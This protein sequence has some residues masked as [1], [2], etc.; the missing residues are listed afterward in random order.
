MRFFIHSFVVTHS[1]PQPTCRASQVPVN[2]LNTG[3][4]DE[5]GRQDPLTRGAVALG[6]Q[7]QGHGEERKQ[8]EANIHILWKNLNKLLGTLAV[9]TANKDPGSYDNGFLYCRLMHMDVTGI[10]IYVHGGLILHT[11][12]KEI[13]QE[14]ASQR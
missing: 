13:G 5:Q 14:K 1:F 9:K 12:G 3:I 7:H 10:E 6:L 2:F 8:K 4:R 11:G